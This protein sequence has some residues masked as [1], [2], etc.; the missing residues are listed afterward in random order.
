MMTCIYLEVLNVFV[1][2]DKSE[3]FNHSLQPVGTYGML[4]HYL[5]TITVQDIAN[6]DML[7]CLS[8]L[9]SIFLSLSLFLF[10]F[11]APRSNIPLAK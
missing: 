3:L 7:N 5:S 4:Y 6:L 9:C 2:Q 1:F 10:V 8:V 11:L